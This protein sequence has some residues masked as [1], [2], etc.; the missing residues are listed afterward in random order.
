MRPTERVVYYNYGIKLRE[1]GSGAWRLESANPDK[2]RDLLGH[3]LLRAFCRCFVRTASEYQALFEAVSND[4]SDATLHIA[5]VF[6]GVLRIRGA[7]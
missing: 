6:M 4:H 2:L 5:E 3:D 7:I 1:F